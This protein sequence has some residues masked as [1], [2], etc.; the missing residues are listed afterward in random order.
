MIDFSRRHLLAGTAAGLVTRPAFGQSPPKDIGER[1]SQA[2]QNGKVSG[3][4]ALLVSHRGKLLL[5]H[6]GQGVD[7]VWAVRSA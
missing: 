1:L 7:E 3:L 4:H 2:L 5:E 6:Y